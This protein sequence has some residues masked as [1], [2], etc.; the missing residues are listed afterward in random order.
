MTDNTTAVEET[1]ETDADGVAYTSE[2]DA[3]ADAALSEV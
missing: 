2:S 1:F 3:S